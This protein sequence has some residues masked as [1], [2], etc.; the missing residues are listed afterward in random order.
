MT[1]NSYNGEIRVIFKYLYTQHNDDHRF[2]ND[3]HFCLKRWNVLI[4]CPLK[5]VT[6][7]YFCNKLLNIF[8]A[9]NIFY[10]PLLSR[11]EVLEGA[12]VLGQL[13]LIGATRAF[14]FGGTG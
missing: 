5:A 12:T 9:E 13:L 8:N 4:L 10:H 14:C 11:L 2:L 3:S 1:M 6:L 7:R